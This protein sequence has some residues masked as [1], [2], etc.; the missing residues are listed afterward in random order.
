MIEAKHKPKKN[1][2]LALLLRVE[3]L[4]SLGLG[5]LISL[6]FTLAPTPLFQ[7]LTH[8]REIL[9]RIGNYTPWLLPIIGFG[10]V[11]FLLDGYFLGLTAGRLLLSVEL[12]KT[13]PL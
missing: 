4:T 5:L 11:A 8:H 13:S 12:I 6:A 3:T 9:D 2:Q 10:S 7:L 1:V